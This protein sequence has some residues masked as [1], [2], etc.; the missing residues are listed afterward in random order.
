MHISQLWA[1][2]SAF[3]GTRYEHQRAQ[4]VRTVS[5]PRNFGAYRSM[6]H[7]RHDK[8]SMRTWSQARGI[9]RV[10]NTTLSSA[11]SGTPLCTLRWL[12]QFRTLLSR[13][14]SHCGFGR[15]PSRCISPLHSLYSQIALFF[16]IH[17][18]LEWWSMRSPLQ[19]VQDLWI[20]QTKDEIH[21]RHIDSQ[22]VWRQRNRRDWSCSIINGKSIKPLEL[23]TNSTNTHCSLADALSSLLD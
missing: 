7:S 20:F 16:S 15:R 2:Y 6:S 18:A 4:A 19:K 5:S 22:T 17:Q 8:P 23:D 9:Y 10:V 11:K 21:D 13:I 3:F 12:N 1:W 14:R